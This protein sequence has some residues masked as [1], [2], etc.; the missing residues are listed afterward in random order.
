MVQHH[1]GAAPQGA[2][3][4]MGP[5]HNQQSTSGGCGHIAQQ[6]AHVIAHEH[7]HQG[8]QNMKKSDDK[9]DFGNI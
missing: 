2:V 1:R 8:H 5:E 6:G 4:H 7:A 3:Q 9:T